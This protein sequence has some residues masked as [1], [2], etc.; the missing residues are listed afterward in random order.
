MHISDAKTHYHDILEVMGDMSNYGSN[1]IP[2]CFTISKR[3]LD[4]AIVLGI[5]L[6]Q[7]VSMF[8]AIEI[9]LSNAAVYPSHLQERVLFEVSIYLEW[10]LKDNTLEKAKYYYVANLR[11]ERLWALRTQ[12]ASEENNAF[13]NLWYRLAI[14]RLILQ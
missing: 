2:R 6:K 11:Q 7:S 10:M 4:D 3:G 5:F 8:D 1:L 13:K 12:D 14:M 9:L